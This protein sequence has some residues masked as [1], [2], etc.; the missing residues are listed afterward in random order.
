MLDPVSVMMVSMC[1]SAALGPNS[2]GSWTS[3]LL[4]KW[5]KY[6]YQTP[7]GRTLAGRTSVH[8]NAFSSSSLGCKVPRLSLKHSLNSSLARLT[9]GMSAGD[10]GGKAPESTEVIWEVKSDD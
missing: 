7:V 6:R 8:S 5:L 4:T 3:A 10:F 9:G 1:Q 2:K